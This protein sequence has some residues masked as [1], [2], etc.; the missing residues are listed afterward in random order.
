MRDGIGEIVVDREE[1]GFGRVVF[2]V[3][4]LEGVK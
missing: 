4:R 1:D 3:K 2:G